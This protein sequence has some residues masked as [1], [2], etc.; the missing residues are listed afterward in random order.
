MHNK[1]FFKTL[2]SNGNIFLNNSYVRER[3]KEEELQ[4][5][6]SSWNY[7]T[8]Q[9]WMEVYEGL[10]SRTS[11]ASWLQSNSRPC[12]RPELTIISSIVLL[13]MGA[14]KLREIKS[15]RPKS[16]AEMENETLLIVPDEQKLFGK[17]WFH[18]CNEGIRVSEHLWVSQVR[19]PRYFRPINVSLHF[20]KC[21]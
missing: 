20:G 15:Q 18:Y 14:N 11:V 5:K 6:Q 16:K 17:H 10:A 8:L 9:Q 3:K 4:T 12:R 2:F 7:I 13:L 19:H 21:A 1:D